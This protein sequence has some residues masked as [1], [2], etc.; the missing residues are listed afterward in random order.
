[1]RVLSCWSVVGLI[2][3]CMFIVLNALLISGA[4]VIA[5]AGGA[6]WLNPF[7]TVLFTVCSA[8]TV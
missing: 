8:I 6:I 3:A 2:S 7:A 5:R 4:T 1:M